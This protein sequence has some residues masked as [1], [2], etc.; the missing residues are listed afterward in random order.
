[1]APDPSAIRREHV[2]GL[3]LAGG[4]GSRMGGLD[5]GLQQH[6][7][8]PLVAHAIARLAPQVGRLIVNANRNLEAYARFGWP[9]C[10]DDT[11]DQ[12]G[13]LAGFVAGLRACDTPWLVTVPC[14]SPAL[15]LDL[16]ARLSAAAHEQ[17]ASV[18]LA[19]APDDSGVLR[20]QPVFCLMHRS[21]LPSLLAFTAAGEAKVGWWARQ[22]GAVQ[23][24]FDDPQAFVN[25]NTL[26][27]LDTLPAPSS[28]RAP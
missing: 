16:V 24:A 2:T 5:K 25:I 8:Q 20:P 3:V 9:V 26:A 23:L 13:P 18:V 1:V 10:S 21:V 11:P 17:R 6:A 4:R 28:P 27:E 12:P 14:D 19:A 15:P 22:Q 7:G